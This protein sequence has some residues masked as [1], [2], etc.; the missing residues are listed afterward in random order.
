[1]E[2]EKKYIKKKEKK[3]TGLKKNKKNSKRAK[4]VNITKEKI[5]NKFVIKDKD[6]NAKYYIYQR[7][8]NDHCD[9]RCRDRKFK[10]TGK[11]IL[12]TGETIVNKEYSIKNYFDHN[13]ATKAFIIPKI[14]KNEMKMK[15]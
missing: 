8:N 10:G 4:S 12:K 3:Q 5:P 11:Y 15:I 9:L 14:E 2:I 6:G 13:Y 1:M 7:K